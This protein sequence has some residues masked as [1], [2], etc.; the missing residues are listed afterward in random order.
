MSSPM[1]S[2]RAQLIERLK[3]IVKRL[4][5]RGD[6][7]VGGDGWFIPVSF[8]LRDALLA[9]LGAEAEPRGWLNEI[10]ETL[11][12]Q[13]NCA[14]SFP[15]FTVQ[16][17]RR[18]YGMDDVYVDDIVWLHSDESV[19]VDTDKA[20]ELEAIYQDGYQQ[21]EGYRRVAYVDTWTFVTACL[22]RA[23][24]ERY[25]ERQRHNLTDPRVYVESGYRNQEWI[26]LL[27]V[28]RALPSPPLSVREREN[29]K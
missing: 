9:A 18:I 27:A 5:A 23:G 28:L 15:I 26:D 19:E 14:T 10:G 1:S 6:L 13:N 16:Q 24:A 25:I 21:P 12:T 7:Q 11:R 20:K 29:E 4:D 2:D 8:D 22:T 17:R 3:A